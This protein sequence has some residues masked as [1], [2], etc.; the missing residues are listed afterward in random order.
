MGHIKE[1]KD[2]DLTIESKPLTANE[3]IAISKHIAD[4]KEKHTK[5]Q[6]EKN[7]SKQPS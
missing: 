2:I 6:S 5:K 7:K 4:Y 1:P 3:R